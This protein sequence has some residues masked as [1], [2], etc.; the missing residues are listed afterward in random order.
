MLPNV[1]SA[2]RVEDRAI[3]EDA[4]KGIIRARRPVQNNTGGGRGAAPPAAEE[5]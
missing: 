5:R 1:L 4:K 2:E 3:E